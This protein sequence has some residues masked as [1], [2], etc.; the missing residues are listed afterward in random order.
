MEAQPI[1]AGSRY[2]F[3]HYFLIEK[4]PV[5]N[6]KTAF[7][8]SKKLVWAIWNQSDIILWFNISQNDNLIV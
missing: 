4:T 2:F 8:S 3:W 1:F 7:Y 6:N 5:N